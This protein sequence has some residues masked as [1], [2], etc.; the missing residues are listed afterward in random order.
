MQ[1]WFFDAPDPFSRALGAILCWISPQLPNLEG[2]TPAAAPPLLASAPP[3][4]SSSSLPSP[5]PLDPPPLDPFPRD[6]IVERVALLRRGAVFR[7]L[8]VEQVASLAMCAQQ[9]C[10]P[11]QARFTK[12]G[13]AYFIMSVTS[14]PK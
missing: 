6:P 5:P 9:K 14:T 7:Q 8:S 10:V 1:T 4:C 11:P 13:E 12:Q 2:A 3:P